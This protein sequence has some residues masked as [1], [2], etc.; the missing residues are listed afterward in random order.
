VVFVLSTAVFV[1]LT[2]VSGTRTRVSIALTAVLAV[3][4][5]VLVF[6]TL[7]LGVAEMF[8]ILDYP[9]SEAAPVLRTSEAGFSIVE[10]IAGARLR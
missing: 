9:F 7:V 4:T 10:K 5:M 2:A 3:P 8:P 1:V 6:S